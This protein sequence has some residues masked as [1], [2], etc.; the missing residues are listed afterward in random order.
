MFLQ[1][2]HIYYHCFCNNNQSFYL[3]SST[4]LYLGHLI[5]IDDL[6][7]LCHNTNTGCKLLLL[8]D[9][10]PNNEVFYRDLLITL[11]SLYVNI[12]QNP[13]QAMS[14]SLT[15]KKFPQSVRQAIKKHSGRK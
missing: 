11:N 10:N 4:E 3:Y 8:C 2:I 12:R 5:S 9:E 13:F 14:S 1:S 6:E 15:S 7:V